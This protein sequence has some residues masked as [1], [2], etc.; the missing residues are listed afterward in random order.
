MPKINV[1]T[2]Q[3]LL[4]DKSSNLLTEISDSLTPKSTWAEFAHP[5]EILAQLRQHM[6]KSCGPNWAELEPETLMQFVQ[7][8]FGAVS[9]ITKSKIWALQ[10]CLTTDIPWN[11]SDAFENCC[12]AFCNQIPIWGVV[13]PL[14]VHEMAFGTGI[15]DAI[16]EEE[17][18]A[19]VQGYQAAVLL[20]NGA[21]DLPP[22][23]PIKNLSPIMNR[24][25]AT[26]HRE[27]AKMAIEEWNVGIRASEEEEVENVLDGQLATFQTVEDWYLAGKQYIPLVVQNRQQ[28]PVQ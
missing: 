6:Y 16:R 18:D 19:E 13:E 2:I 5:L 20:Y 9:E 23:S 3:D 4:S 27:L 26:E 25:L 14:D 21:L 17:F 10:L 7:E 22:D 24:Q 8:E 12:L 11:D 15:L 1:P 28:N